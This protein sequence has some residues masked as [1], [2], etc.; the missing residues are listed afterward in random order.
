M[1]RHLHPPL[2]ILARPKMFVLKSYI[3]TVNSC[4]FVIHIY[5]NLYFTFSHP[6]ALDERGKRL[7]HLESKFADLAANSEA[8]LKN[9]RALNQREENKW[10][11]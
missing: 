6:Q 2:R 5:L 3:L 4:P 10:F 11:W 1:N 7:H 8:F 9:A